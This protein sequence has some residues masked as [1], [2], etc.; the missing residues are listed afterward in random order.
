MV[1]IAGQTDIVVQVEPQALG[2]RLRRIGLSFIDE[3]LRT[4]AHILLYHRLH[5]V[6]P[7]WH[8][9]LGQGLL[10][11]AFGNPVQIGILHNDAPYHAFQLREKH[12][13]VRQRVARQ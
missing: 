10:L 6:T 5:A 4:A 3:R 8:G 9:L 1:R 2:K 12:L 13:E 7:V 11:F